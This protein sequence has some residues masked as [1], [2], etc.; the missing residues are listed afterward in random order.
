MP[1]PWGAALYDCRIAHVRT[2][3]LRHAF[4]H[5]TYL[6]L[7]DL[8][9]LPRLPAPLRPLA[10]FQARDHLGDPAADLRRNLDGYL[11]E[12]GIDLRGGQ[13][14]MLAHAR[15]LGHVF[16]PITVYWCH[17]A[18]GAPVCTVAEVHN[19][20]RE[21]HR[22]LL[23]P[24]AEGRAETAKTFYVS[25]FF[26]V[27]GGYR[28]VLPEPGEQLRLTV[29][30]EREGGRALTATVHGARRAATP[31]G[32]LRAAGRHPLSTLVVS[33]HIRIQGLRLLA[34]GLPV[35]P[36]PRRGACPATLP[37]QNGATRR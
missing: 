21:R 20:Y 23:F 24:D 33:A 19:T 10:R 29:H 30:L 11:A 35:Q 34:R 2:R 4:Q 17:D 37:G 28:M 26:P 3:P 15:S 18:G 9:R 8:D 32:L 27:D 12:H 5:R 13:V 6:W 1:G 7:V 22:Y 31:L 14:L 25:P 36:R 16:N